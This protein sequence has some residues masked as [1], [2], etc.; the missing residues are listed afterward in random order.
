VD[1]RRHSAMEKLQITSVA[2][3]AILLAT[4]TEELV[5]RSR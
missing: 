3:F 2:D 4:A 1:R 5:P